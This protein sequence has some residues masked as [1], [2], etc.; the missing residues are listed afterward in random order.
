MVM[1]A[2]ILGR[3][4]K[5]D[6]LVHCTAHTC[7]HVSLRGTHD[8][9]TICFVRITHTTTHDED[10]ST[11]CRRQRPLSIEANYNSHHGVPRKKNDI[12][13]IVSSPYR[14]KVSRVVSVISASYVT[15]ATSLLSI[16]FAFHTCSSPI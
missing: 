3:T 8:V 13:G 1:A 15:L 2:D 9:C 6:Y 11:D 7:K 5:I 12:C 14:Y 10:A 4:L 16:Y